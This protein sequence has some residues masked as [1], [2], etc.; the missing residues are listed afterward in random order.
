MK[1]IVMGLAC[2]LMLT[3]ST[4]AG[5]ATGSE[6]TK[7]PS[8]WWQNP[9]CKTRVGLSDGQAAELERIFLSVREELRA[10]KA[11]LEKQETSLSRLLSDSTADEAVV[12][13]TIDRVEAARSALAKT[14]TL[15]LYRMHRMLSPE[16]RVRLEAFEREQ[17]RGPEPA[18]PK[19]K[20]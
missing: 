17:A 2:L 7:S 5:A 1:T 13:R 19:P 14:R 3:L 11:E 18:T 4:A 9:V 6:T 10:E 8:K 20:D 16:Q 12:V 15:M